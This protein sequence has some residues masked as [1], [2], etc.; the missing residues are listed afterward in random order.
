LC[1]SPLNG[2]EQTRLVLEELSFA[3]GHD[4]MCVASQ[5]AARQDQVRAR[6]RGCWN[7]AYGRDEDI[8]LAIHT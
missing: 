5:F 1:Q 2:K 4:L 8:T 7:G 6:L 3:L